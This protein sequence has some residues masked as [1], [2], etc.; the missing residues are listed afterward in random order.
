[1]PNPVGWVDPLGLVCKEGAITTYRGDGRSP[2]TIFSE[3]FQPKGTSTDLENYAATNEPSIY[4]STSKDPDVAIDFATNYGTKDGTIYTVRS[5]NGIDVNQT[6]GKR[7]PF[8]EEH[9][10]AIPGGIQ[11]DQILGA[12]PVNADGSYVGYTILNPKVY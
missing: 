12:T 11:P 10:I 2:E 5:T 1:M 3:G 7:S 9:E 8:P 6:L 4:V